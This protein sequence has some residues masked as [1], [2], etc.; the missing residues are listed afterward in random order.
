MQITNVYPVFFMDFHVADCE[1]IPLIVAPCV[2][3]NSQKQIILIFAN[4]NCTIKVSTFKKWVKYD[5]LVF[6]IFILSNKRSVC[7]FHACWRFK[8][9]IWKIK[10]HFVPCEECIIVTR[11]IIA[12]FICIWL[13]LKEI[14][15]KSIK[16]WALDCDRNR[17]GVFFR[18]HPASLDDINT[19]WLYQDRGNSYHWW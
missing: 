3:I 9:R 13:R 8:M 11:T 15:E 7:K 6:E 1:V 5:V 18:A 14:C 16:V 12:Y 19:Q 4:M 10:W 2:G 17:M